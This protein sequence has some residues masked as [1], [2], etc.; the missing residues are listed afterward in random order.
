MRHVLRPASRQDTHDVEIGESDDQAE[1]NGD[2]D[3]IAHHRQSDE[4][5]L[6]HRIGPVDR[7]RLIELWFND[8]PEELFLISKGKIEARRGDAHSTGE[9]TERSAFVALSPEKFGRRLDGRIDV[10]FAWT[11]HSCFLL[12][13]TTH[14]I[15]LTP[16]V[17][18]L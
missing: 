15:N 11:S 17:R 18:I 10:E 6:L 3:D 9:I 12:F 14:Y 16:N 1:Q 8:Y 2:R 7:R 13:Y 4:E 5:Q